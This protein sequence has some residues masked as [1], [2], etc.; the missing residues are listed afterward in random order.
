MA[1]EKLALI[2]DQLM[3]DAP[4]DQ[5]VEFLENY[6]DRN[7]MSPHDILDVACGTGAVSIKLL[8]KGYAV[9]G[10]DLSQSMLAIAGQRVQENG[11]SMPL[12]EQDMRTL[13]LGQTFDVI[14]IFC[15]SI[16]Y[17][18]DFNDVEKTFAASARHL[19]PGGLL[20]FDVH[21][22]E[23]IDIGFVNQSFSYQDNDLAYIWD[24]F[25]GEAPHSVEHEITFFKELKT[26]LYERFDELHFQRTYPVSDLV[27]ALERAGYS[28]IKVYQDFSF[29]E[30]QEE[31][32]RLFFFAVKK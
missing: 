4:Y 16:N 8:K 12:Y 32:E 9:T 6:L 30:P 7:G 14:T 22:T 19:K 5:W 10:V 27:K 31:A 24:S 28:S 21:S 1:Y 29:E 13:E 25:P 26:G 3:A 17:L 2:Y 20:A 23:K 18:S 11:F 15:D